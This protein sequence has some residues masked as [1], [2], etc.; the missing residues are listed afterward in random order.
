MTNAKKEFT[1]AEV[2]AEAMGWR[3]EGHTDCLMLRMLDAF[4]VRLAEDEASKP[5]F[6]VTKPG[7]DEVVTGMYPDIETSDE[8]DAVFC[9][10]L[11]VRSKP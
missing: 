10:P 5:A 6:W 1:R 2:E 9:V 11:Y 8:E 4:A 3:K 7:L